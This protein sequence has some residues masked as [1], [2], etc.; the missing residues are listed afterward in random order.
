MVYMEVVAPATH[1]HFASDKATGK[2]FC[3]QFIVAR[4][5]AYE[6]P[7]EGLRVA[8]VYLVVHPILYSLK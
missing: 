5:I 3:P 1:L 6:K 7:S 4:E 8:L 2:R